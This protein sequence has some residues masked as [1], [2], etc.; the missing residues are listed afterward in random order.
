MV[1]GLQTAPSLARLFHLTPPPRAESTLFLHA[2]GVFYPQ[3]LCGSRYGNQEPSCTVFP[4]QEGGR[5]WGNRLGGSLQLRPSNPLLIPSS[6]LTGL[7]P[8]VARLPCLGSPPGFLGCSSPHHSNLQ[9]LISWRNDLHLTRELRL[10]GA[11]APGGIPFPFP[12]LFS[13]LFFSN[14]LIR[15]YWYGWAGWTLHKGALCQPKPSHQCPFLLCPGPPCRLTSALL[16]PML[17]LG[18]LLGEPIMSTRNVGSGH[19]PKP[20]R[21]GNLVRNLGF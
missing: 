9:S 13:S 21:K 12:F 1:P 3:I 20:R 17:T 14:H 5:G 7:R 4:L 16:Q 2:P 8:Q 11:L 15:A 10:S 19:T 18:S 6:A